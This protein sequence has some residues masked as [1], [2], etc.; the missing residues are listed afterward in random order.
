MRDQQHRIS[1]HANLVEALAAHRPPG[2]V[3]SFVPLP[4]R[5]SR[6][7]VHFA[8]NLVVAAC[9]AEILDPAHL[10]IYVVIVVEAGLALA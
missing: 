9:Q 3:R 6:E 2:I 4:N 7:A 10:C 5:R 1:N 8:E